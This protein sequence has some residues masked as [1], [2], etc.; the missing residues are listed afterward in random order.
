MKIQELLDGIRK[1][2]LV[3]PEFQREYVWRK[4]QA[5]QLMVSLVKDYPVGSLLFWKTNQP[6]ELKNISD[7]PEKLG[8]FT[9]IL[10]GQQRL[11]T[12]Y[13]LLTGEIP[14]Y[15]RDTEIT[16][17]PRELYFNIETGD[18]QYYQAS[19]MRGNP[20]WVRVTECYQ[21]QSVNPVE[22][23]KEVS[24]DEEDTVGLIEKFYDNLN[25]L[26]NIQNKDLTIQAVP[27]HAKLEDAIDIFDRVNRQGTKLSEADLALTHITGKWSKARREFKKK[28]V[29]LEKS[30][31]SFDLTFMTRAL[32]AVTTQRALFEV[33]HKVEKDKL[34]EGWKILSKILDY[35]V[36]ILP[37]QAFINNTNDLNTTNVLIP[38]VAYLSK[39]DGKFSNQQ[40]M[41]NALHWLYAAH[42][43]ARYTSQTSQRLESDLSIVA[44]EDS[45]WEAL[46]NEIIDQR[47]R[48]TVKA[49]D[50]EG[51]GMNHPLFRM[52]IIVAKS[53]DAVDWFN[54]V[55]IANP[56]TGSYSIH[57]HHIF[58]SSRLYD[59]VYDSDN[60]L[61]KKI[62]NEI[63]N[64]AILTADSNQSVSNDLPADYLPDVLEKYPEALNDQF[65]PMI[66]G[67]WEIE[68][69]ADFIE[70]RREI[71]SMKINEFMD[72]LIIETEERQ[73][74][75]IEELII[76][77]ES[78][79]LEFKSTLQWDVVQNTKNKSLRKQSL[80]TIAAFLN[81]SGGIL[82]IGV[83]DEGQIFGLAPDLSLVN[84]SL[85]KFGVLL[86]TLIADYIGAEFA[87][88]LD[89]S[90]EKIGEEKICKI[91][92][93]KSHTPVY[94]KG[95]R[96]SEFWT[97]FGPTSRVLDAEE[98]MDYINQNWN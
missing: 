52:A 75:T 54:G 13:L 92:V 23:A 26:K 89:I 11:T 5:K 37:Q 8:N 27:V 50:F 7:L 24:N 44:R 59:D 42:T 45:P 4:E 91:S 49:S 2:D 77:G 80:K 88:L 48:M 79:T 90:Y 16:V 6:P 86:T 28:I 25:N 40:S 19:K 41:K 67:L 51:R 15:Y 36:D 33:L 73:E 65:V 70:K 62:V 3:L 78:T 12:L 87:P 10:D 60:H 9:V 30:G 98:T 22:V 58:P 72:N 46:R 47:G 1:Q 56:S 81:S 38:W 53:N 68:R 96:G 32:N 14:P 63:A 64:R 17:D 29:E 84:G 69:F 39:N 85:D 66:P 21:D 95:D 61:H 83:E 57:R 94:M 76:L 20:V 34:I 82:L 71:M 35:L 18:F 31:F 55:P 97:R 74:R 93:E 43:W